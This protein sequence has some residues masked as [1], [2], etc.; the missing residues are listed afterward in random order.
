MEFKADLELA[1]M[2]QSQLVHY[3]AELN[4]TRAVS[5]LNISTPYLFARLE[6]RRYCNHTDGVTPLV[7]D[8][9]RFHACPYCQATYTFVEWV[10]EVDGVSTHHF[11]TFNAN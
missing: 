2:S 10:D 8:A 1:L 5:D 3:L 7:P 6:A 4:R 11:K 9:P